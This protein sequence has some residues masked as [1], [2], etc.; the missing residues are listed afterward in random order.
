MEIPYRDGKN[1]VGKGKG[2]SYLEFLYTRWWVEKGDLGNSL[3][4]CF[5]NRDFPLEEG[6]GSRK[7]G[8]V[9][10]QWNS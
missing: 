10:F 2:S 8:V 6:G 5:P 3:G 7:S 9:V 4:D 1:H